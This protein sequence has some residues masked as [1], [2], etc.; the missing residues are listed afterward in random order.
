MFRIYSVSYTHLDVYKRQYLY[1]VN[2]H[3]QII[4]SILLIHS[5]HNEI[6]N[7]A[8]YKYKV[9]STF[10]IKKFTIRFLYYNVLKSL[11]ILQIGSRMQSLPESYLAI[12]VLQIIVSS[13]VL[14][15][16]CK[17]YPRTV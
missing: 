11:M 3:T 1:T 13:Q 7:W 8:I 2:I 4:H 17:I 5:S 12:H 6:M 15:V 9:N 10:A 14:K 16:E